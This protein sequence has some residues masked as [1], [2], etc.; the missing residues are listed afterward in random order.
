ME[1]EPFRQ[2][3]MPW[4]WGPWVGRWQEIPIS[5]RLT[6][7][8]G[9]C[10]CQERVLFTL[11]KYLQLHFALRSQLMNLATT[12]F[13]NF[14]LILLIV[15]MKLDQFLKGTKYR[16]VQAACSLQKHTV[17]CSRPRGGVGLMLQPSSAAQ[18][19]C[20]VP[21]TVKLLRKRL[22]VMDTTARVHSQRPGRG[23]SSCLC[24][25]CTVPKVQN[26]LFP[27][28]SGNSDLCFQ[29]PYKSPRFSPC[30]ESLLSH[31]VS[32]DQ[33]HTTWLTSLGL[34]LPSGHP[35][36]TKL[37]LLPPLSTHMHIQAHTQTCFCSLPNTVKVFRKN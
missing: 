1:H 8:G 14:I 22:F 28:L 5:D 26:A 20:P 34:S 19:L 9:N 10:L 31:Q 4:R 6:N 27:H 35:S 11:M 32:R 29:S 13:K 7:N 24:L 30:N 17:K 25:E 23:H 36:P 15:M 12:L 21:S 2:F 18:T 16:I 37:T 3:Y 33:W